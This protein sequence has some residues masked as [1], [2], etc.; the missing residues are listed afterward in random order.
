MTPAYDAVLVT[1]RTALD[2]LDETIAE[3]PDEA[4]DWVPAPG[5]NSVAVLTRHSVTGTAYL[6]ACGAGLTPD[7]ETYLREDR[8]EAFRTMG[9]TVAGLRGEIAKLKADLEPI[10]AQG[11]DDALTR[12]ALWA[13]PEN[14]RTP[15]CGELAV[16]SVGHLKEHVGQVQMLRDLWQAANPGR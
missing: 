6:A 14:G 16:H 8:A 12:P 11:T 3:L 5:L 15:S 7:R 4:L 13:W 1:A 10:L 9:A 2:V